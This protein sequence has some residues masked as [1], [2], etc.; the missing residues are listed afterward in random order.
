MRR[1]GLVRK[2]SSINYYRSLRSVGFDLRP[3]LYEDDRVK[4]IKLSSNNFFEN[5]QNYFDL[6]YIDGDHETNQVHKDINNSWKILNKGGY[7][8]LDDYTWW[9][10]KDL[11]KNP[12]SAI[13]NFIY[14]S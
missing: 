6:I 3:S 1:K 2:K 4:K 9:W 5:N 8:I 12:A 7:M 10:Y 11:N 13:N 14:N